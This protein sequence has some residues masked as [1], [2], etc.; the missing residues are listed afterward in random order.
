MKDRL[1]IYENGEFNIRVVRNEQGEPLFC[2]KDVCEELGLQTKQVV[3][4]L[5]DDVFSKHPIVDSLGRTQQATF[6]NEDGL[7][8]T[9]LESRKSEAKRFRK[10]VT[11]EVLPDIRRH[12]GYIVAM[13]DEP[14]EVIIA[15]ALQLTHNRL[16]KRE[17]EIAALRPM[18][19]YA[20]EVLLSETCLTTRQIAKEL[21]MTAQALNR[22][23]EA[24]RIQFYQS[25]QWML[26]R[27]YADKGLSQNRTFHYRD[28]KAQTQIHMVWTERGRL[29]IHTKVKQWKQE[30]AADLFTL[31]SNTETLIFNTH[32]S[33]EEII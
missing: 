28:S 29:F 3:R 11:S 14:D 6:V 22:L 8:D 26:Y 33:Y 17:K 30:Q 9:I 31:E 7:Y 13:A 5:M 25:G 16:Q 1:E 19:E 12:G 18:A 23:L 4:R 24:H 15:R 10:W 21:G 2:L 27:E 20:E 32:I